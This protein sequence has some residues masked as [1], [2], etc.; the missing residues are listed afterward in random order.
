MLSIKLSWVQDSVNH[1]LKMWP[2]QAHTTTSSDFI[3]SLSEICCFVNF[4]WAF[5]RSIMSRRCFLKMFEFKIKLVSWTSSKQFGI[6]VAFGGFEL[7]FC[8]SSLPV[9]DCGWSLRMFLSSQMN[10]RKSSQMNKRQSCLRQ[11]RWG[12]CTR[13]CNDSDDR[14]GHETFFVHFQMKLKEVVENLPIGLNS[15]KHSHEK[16]K[17]VFKIQKPAIVQDERTRS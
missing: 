3:S 4:R 14:S 16:P 10:K 8:S 2:H 1:S 6:F 5:S 12:N 17:I 15:F 11:R 7:S 13:R 9:I